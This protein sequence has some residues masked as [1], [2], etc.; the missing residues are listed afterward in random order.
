MGTS[1]TT[2]A[3]DVTGTD[4]GHVPQ[5]GGGECIRSATGPPQP[6][7]DSV[8]Q[9]CGMFGQGDDKSRYK[10]HNAEGVY[11]GTSPK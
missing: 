6:R 8:I 11:I 4:P 10:Y 2:D 1:T 7:R 3:F 9:W 5:R